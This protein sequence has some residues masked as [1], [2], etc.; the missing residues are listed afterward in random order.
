MGSHPLLAEKIQLLQQVLQQRGLWK[1]QTPVWVNHYS[2][3]QQLESMDFFGWLQFIYLPNILL[4][5]KRVE[6]NERLIMLQA[7]E[8]LKTQETTA[9]L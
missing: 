2:A 7:M 3:G 8:Y 9:P 1:K 6:A 4:H 5:G